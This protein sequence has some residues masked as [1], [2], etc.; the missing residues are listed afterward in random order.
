LKFFFKKILIPLGKVE[1]SFFFNRK[2][3][4]WKFFNKGMLNDLLKKSVVLVVGK[5]AEEIAILIHSKR[6]VNEFN[7]AKKMDL[8][9]NQTRNIL[10]KLSDQGL[11]SFTRKKDKKK[12]WY[13]YFW[14]IEV[15]KSLVFLKGN[16]V[17]RIGQFQ[18]RIHSRESKQF[19][20]CER[21]SIE[22]TEENA[23]LRDFTCPECGGV[24]TVKDNTK[25]V[26]E[27]NKHLDKFKAELEL[28]DVEIAK[29]QIKL[30]KVRAKEIK[31]SEKEKEVKKAESAEKR[32]KTR[33]AKLKA[34]GKPIPLRKVAKKKVAKKKTIA[35]KKVVIKKEVVKKK[36]AKK[37][38]VASKKTLKSL[39]KKVVKKKVAKKKIVKR[40]K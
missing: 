30:D 21:C 3:F 15:M 6:P 8:T 10:Y 4:I 1:I 2:V 36:V 7:V 17:K 18:E 5:P 32:R 27:L 29:E 16:L 12:G 28:I 9:I 37:K 22:F 40:K 38:I 33:E 25:V 20:V 35:K 31:V 26:R 24:F 39:V 23:L 34:Q 13:T 14:K 19:F 11:V